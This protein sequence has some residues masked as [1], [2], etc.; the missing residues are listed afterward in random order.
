MGGDQNATTLARFFLH[1]SKELV[2]A[3]VGDHLAEI[4]YGPLCLPYTHWK[5]DHFNGAQSGSMI[6]NLANQLRMFAK[7]QGFYFFTLFL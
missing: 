4:C 5:Q 7:H 3:S 2:G 6:I 1:Y